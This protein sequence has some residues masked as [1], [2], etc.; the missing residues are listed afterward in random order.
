MRRLPSDSAVM[1]SSKLGWLRFPKATASITATLS[2]SGARAAARLA[3][4]RPPPTMIRPYSLV[5]AIPLH[6]AVCGKGIY[7]RGTRR[8]S[9][10]SRMRETGGPN[11]RPGLRAKR[12]DSAIFESEKAKGGFFRLRT[13]SNATLG[14]IA[15]HVGLDGVGILHERTGEHLRL[16]LGHQN[17]VLDAHA[18]T[19]VALGRA[20]G[21]GGDVD[22]RFHREHHAGL[23]LAPLL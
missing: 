11:S 17:V 8:K 7:R 4:T 20:L 5:P 23:E 19:L 21:A 15:A 22:P 3:P 14:R 9:W 12:E 18:D 2:G 6:H 10:V 1:R 16:A 13:R